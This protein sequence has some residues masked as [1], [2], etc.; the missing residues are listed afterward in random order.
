MRYFFFFICIS[1]FL[2]VAYGQEA[3]EA[4]LERLRAEEDKKIIAEERQEERDAEH[5][6]T[7]GTGRVRTLYLARAQTHTWNAAQDNLCR[8]SACSLSLL[9]REDSLSL[10][11][12]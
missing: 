2:N 8:A 10:Q 5:T 12:W 1:L 6:V 4:E 3:D 11:C 7:N 9:A